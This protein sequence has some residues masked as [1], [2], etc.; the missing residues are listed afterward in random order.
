MTPYTCFYLPRIFYLRG[1][2]ASKE[3]RKD[4][5]R[6]YYEKFLALSGPDPLIWGEEKK[7]GNK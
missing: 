3:G 6:G 1:L 5:A 7:V 2:L 4:D